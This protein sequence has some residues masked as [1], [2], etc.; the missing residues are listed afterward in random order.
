MR[1][2]HPT[3]LAAAIALSIAALAS[4]GHAALEQRM[5]VETCSGPPVVGEDACAAR[6]GGLVADGAKA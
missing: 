4:G 3:P 5:S 2:S 6:P 1:I